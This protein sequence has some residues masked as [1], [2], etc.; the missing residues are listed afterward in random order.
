MSEISKITGEEKF[1]D[2]NWL[3]SVFGSPVSL[4]DT[5]KEI[6][7]ERERDPD[8]RHDESPLGPSSLRTLLRRNADAKREISELLQ[9]R[10]DNVAPKEVDMSQFDVQEHIATA[11]WFDAYVANFNL[12]HTGQSL[13]KIDIYS[14][15]GTPDKKAHYNDDGTM[16]DWTE[17]P[18]FKEFID[19]GHGQ[20][21]VDEQVVNPQHAHF[22]AEQIN[23][24]E[25]WYETAARGHWTAMLAAGFTDPINLVGFGWARKGMYA[26]SRLN[27]KTGGKVKTILG[28][29]T[30]SSGHNA[31]KTVGK[32]VGGGAGVSTTVAILEPLRWELD[33]LAGPAQS[34]AII[35]G[36]FVIGGAFVSLV[37]PTFRSAKRIIWDKN[38]KKNRVDR[39]DGG[40][41]GAWAEHIIAE[42]KRN[43]HEP[44][45]ESL[46]YRIQDDMYGIVTR[47]EGFTG[48]YLL[49]NG[50]ILKVKDIDN[51]AH[52]L[53]ISEKGWEYL[54]IEVLTN[55]KT[56]G[57][58][59]RIEI[60]W[61]EYNIMEMWKSGE[62]KKSVPAYIH[63][64]INNKDDLIEFL[65]KK[66]IFRKFIHPIEETKMSPKEH[67]VF[68]EEATA[69]DLI[70]RS[71][72]NYT[73]KYGEIPIF[74]PFMKFMNQWLD[75]ELGTKMF[76]KDV[77]LQNYIARNILSIIDDNNVPKNTRE[78]SSKQSVLNKKMTIHLQHIRQ[79]ME[80]IMIDFNQYHTGRY[81]KT[82]ETRVPLA[83]IHINKFQIEMQERFG[84]NYEKVMRAIN[85]EPTPR[86][87]KLLKSEYEQLVAK[88]VMIED[89]KMSNIKDPA[90]R[91]SIQRVRDFLK[92]YETDI[93]DVG[94]MATKENLL[95]NKFMYDAVIKQITKILDDDKKQQSKIESREKVDLPKLLTNKQRKAYEKALQDVT[96]ERNAYGL[97]KKVEDITEI[98]AEK[99]YELPE[100]YYMRRYLTDPMI[101]H[102]VTFKLRILPYFIAE[103]LNARGLKIDTNNK[104]PHEFSVEMR[105]LLAQ[106]GVK[107]RKA[108]LKDALEASNT[109]HNNIVDIHS[110]YGEIEGGMSGFIFER[111]IKN[112][113][114]KQSSLIFRQLKIPSKVFLDVSVIGNSNQKI[115]FIST[116]LLADLAVYTD[117]ISTA[118]EVANIHGDKNGR[119]TMWE[120]KLKLLAKVKNDNDVTAMNQTTS[121]FENAI[122]KLYGTFSPT[123]PKNWITRAGNILK[124][125]VVPA[126][127]T[128]V[129]IT[130]LPDWANLI[131]VHGWNKT[132]DAIS[133]NKNLKKILSDAEVKALQKEEAYMLPLLEEMANLSPYQRQIAYDRLPIGS[134]SKIPQNIKDRLVN[135][136]DKG[137][138]MVEHGLQNFNTAYFQSIMLPQFTGYVKKFAALISQHRFIED[139]IKAG[140]GKLSKKGRDRLRQYGFEDKDIKMFMR[141]FKAGLIDVKK[142]RITRTFSGFKDKEAVAY[143]PNIEKWT[144]S[145]IL[146]ADSFSLLFRQAVKADAE[147]TILT[148]SPADNMNLA[149]GGIHAYSERA[150]SIIGHPQFK[151]VLNAT[152]TGIGY[153]MG[154]I[155]GA[156][157]GLAMGLGTTITKGQ[158]QVMIGHAALKLF[159][160]FQ[161]W[162]R[163]A[164]RV[165][166]INSVAGTEESYVVGTASAVLLG[167]F[168]NYIKDPYG[169]E[170]L[171][172]KEEYQEFW[173]RAATNSGAFH[174]PLDIVNA[175]D[176]STGY[177]YGGR[178]F[179]GLEPPYG[180]PDEDDYIRNFGALPNIL[181]E[182]YDVF[183]HGTDREQ[184]DWY[185][186]NLPYN[187]IPFGI[188]PYE[189]F[190][191]EEILKPLVR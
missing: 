34:P 160:M 96:H 15:M 142:S 189:G 98:N 115:D 91:N 47:E 140:T 118:I 137:T 125:M 108:L 57:T 173:Y 20:I 112:N 179:L 55:P 180:N 106:L 78:V 126:K 76:D 100:N 133:L 156:T 122:N 17:D 105:T 42:H 41:E 187:K 48:R 66:E 191:E 130:S 185:T 144:N 36:A 151:D 131:L 80:D 150:Q 172:E 155:T 181:N 107:E 101:E 111:L 61:D 182:T 26:I 158:N 7:E 186:K 68:I 16:W 124:D 166:G 50:G 113:K 11:N 39:F 114:N 162:T 136:I 109:I 154:D 67:K 170:R 83:R 62:W 175:I 103:R 157:T 95:R 51:V 13:D 23:R 44:H 77:S 70:I 28:A 71:K 22:L 9:K 188:R 56:K 92:M 184:A 4:G 49:D 99:A 123:D 143:I 64:N 129:T 53:Q 24:N 21:F 69:N 60:K 90:M 72:D 58:Q 5:A 94:L 153:S 37:H 168:A 79:L 110:K 127:L 174:V 165:R 120:M 145:D 73:T 12:W 147:R 82:Y 89:A 54:P 183:H 52:P 27:K 117:K 10:Y 25:Q 169:T 121:A 2:V 40:E 31:M 178:G 161:G 84:R 93:T 45:Y 29:A 134:Q 3:E 88:L 190:V 75:I 176:Q 81:D 35:A 43:N 33:P 74:S 86:D 46:Q 104:Y 116:N 135:K 132:F 30:F 141:I 32:F 159:F 19:R 171:L 8:F 164:L 138:S 87:K 139:L 85:Q 38:F 148:P 149:Y 167:G 59:T 152:L 128:Q 177:R 102:P 63:K 6:E 18:Y 163:K 65:T 14:D 119:A 97:N 1:D 146:G